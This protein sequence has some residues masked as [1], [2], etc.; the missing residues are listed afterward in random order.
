MI[1]KRYSGRRGF[2]R[3]HVRHFS[4]LHALL[5]FTTT[6]LIASISPLWSQQFTT[7]VRS[8]FDGAAKD[9]SLTTVSP[10]F[11]VF[12]EREELLYEVSY[13]GIKL[14]SISTRIVSVTPG[15]QGLRIKVEGL[16]RTY[17]GVPFVT[18]NTLYRS[19]IGESLSSVSFTN[20][21]Y[22]SSHGVY[23]YIEY[24]Y[25]TDKDRV[26]VHET[27]E[28]HPS[29]EKHDTLTLDGQRWQDGLSLFYYARAFSH[30][31]RS[32]DIPVLMYRDKATTSIRFGVANERVSIDA[33]DYRVHCRK[34]EGETGFTG[35]FGLTGAFEGWFSDDSA[36]IPIRAKM[37]V[38]IG[39][40]K[41]ELIKWKR[42]GW[43]PPQH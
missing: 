14:G 23:K 17:K 9:A 34:L 10:N 40:V 12:Q 2:D 35:I 8:D 38:L 42:R 11:D 43:R 7:T 15:D 31:N 3:N 29:W 25:A 36:A 19:V 30:S 20:K 39:S 21:E 27:V 32:R 6:L 37:H 18:L 26:Y 41:I 22:L 33:A 13:L 24:V 1:N 16:V 5:L 4:A 28:R